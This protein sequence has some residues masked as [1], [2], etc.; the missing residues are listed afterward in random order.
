MTLKI[1]LSPEHVHNLVVYHILHAKELVNDPTNIHFAR[2]MA[3]WAKMAPATATRK[4]MMARGLRIDGPLSR[5]S[6]FKGFMG[7]NLAP[8]AVKMLRADMPNN[9]PLLKVLMAQ[10]KEE[11]AELFKSKYVSPFELVDHGEDRIML[12]PLF[13]CTLQD[14][15]MT[16][17]LLV[18]EGRKLVEK[19]MDG[20]QAMHKRG[21][22]HGDIKPSNIAL[23]FHGDPVLIDFGSVQLFDH[24]T[25]ST[26]SFVPL[27]LRGLDHDC[28]SLATAQL[29]FAMLGMT[30]KYVTEGATA[31]G[32][33]SEVDLQELKAYLGATLG[34]S[35]KLLGYI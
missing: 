28:M 32:D 8:Q 3:T 34:A 25:H 20:L 12:M 21:V 24:R 5:G 10:A 14:L 18:P 27:S 35:H 33:A 16:G 9:V 15:C 22:G 1:A 30:F 4:D 2:K 29:D 26:H 19:L 6:V 31:Y 7:N 13:A 17:P 23:N 11:G